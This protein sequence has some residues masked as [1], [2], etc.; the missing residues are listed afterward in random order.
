MLDAGVRLEVAVVIPLVGLGGQFFYLCEYLT[1]VS[2]CF[3]QHAL[4]QDFDQAGS[5]R[6]LAPRHG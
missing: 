1:G 4:V 6:K 3:D 2:L 5:L